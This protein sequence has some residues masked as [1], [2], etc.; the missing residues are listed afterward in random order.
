MTDFSAGNPIFER[1]S[2][3][4]RAS[5][6]FIR[7]V[8][9]ICIGVA[10]TLAWQSYGEATKQM[11]AMRAPQLGWSPEAQQMIAS[12]IQWLGWTQ[13]AAG[14]EN[15]APETVAPK[16]SLD[17]AQAQQM[18]QSLAA[19][20]ETVEQLAAGQDQVAREIGQLE[21]VIAELVLKIPEPTLQHPTTAPVRKTAPPTS[22]APTAAPQTSRTPMPLH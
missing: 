21:S 10:A 9:A 15:T 16:A 8:V 4:R 1:P 7:Y 13:P 17:P 19:L 18:T 12:S 11:I 14:P 6:A 5:R 20:R 3:A 22:R 2:R